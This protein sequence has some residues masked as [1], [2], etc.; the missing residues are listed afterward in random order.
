M[1]HTCAHTNIHTT[2]IHESTIRCKL[3]ALTLPMYYKTDLLHIRCKILYLLKI[4]IE[5]HILQAWKWRVSLP[6]QN[7]LWMDVY[8]HTHVC[9]Y[10]CTFTNIWTC[11]HT[12]IIATN[13]TYIYRTSHYTIL[14]CIY[15]TVL[16]CTLL[17]STLLYST[18]L[19]YTILYYTNI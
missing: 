10:A 7:K 12:H 6:K 16:Y 17:Y 15:C 19:Y 8:R 3:I 13:P 14:Y 4:Y 9:M 18:L 5:V 11:T 2:C 1:T